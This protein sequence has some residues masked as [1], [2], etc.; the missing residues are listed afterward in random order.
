MHLKFYA[1]YETSCVNVLP[2]LMLAYNT[3]NNSMGG[4]S[5]FRSG[6]LRPEPRFRTFYLW[7]IKWYS[8]LFL[9][10]KLSDACKEH[11]I[12]SYCTQ[13][14]CQTCATALFLVVLVARRHHARQKGRQTCYAKSTYS[15]V[16]CGVSLTC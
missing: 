11:N 8:P 10:K 12:N 16:K 1:I 15:G 6:G 4:V 14:S 9:L 13:V 2:E 3:P 7:Q 5:D